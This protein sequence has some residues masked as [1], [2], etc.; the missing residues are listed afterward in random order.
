MQRCIILQTHAYIFT[1]ILQVIYSQ[2]ISLW[3]NI[4]LFEQRGPIENYP[5]CQ[6]GL[7][8]LGNRVR[9]YWGGSSAWCI[10]CQTKFW[11]RSLFRCLACHTLPY[12]AISLPCPAIPCHTLP[13]PS[14]PRRV[15]MAPVLLVTTT[16]S[17]MARPLGCTLTKN[18]VQDQDQVQLHAQE[19]VLGLG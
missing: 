19:Q 4:V 1:S 10:S 3:M 5:R 14:C 2:S 8:A 15:L 16:R 6:R 17:T 11:G 18:Q 7:V 9:W 13:W 12:P